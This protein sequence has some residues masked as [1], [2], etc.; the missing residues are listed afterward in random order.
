[1]MKNTTHPL[2][3]AALLCLAG[4]PSDDTSGDTATSSTGSTGG[5]TTQTPTTDPGS[6]STSVGSTSSASTTEDGTTSTGTVDTGSSSSEGSSSSSGGETLSAIVSAYHGLDVLPAGGAVVLCGPPGVGQDGM[7]VAFAFQLNGDTVVP[8]NFSVRDPDGNDVTPTCATLAPADEPLELHTV[9]LAGP[10][11][12]DGEIPL[13]VEVTGPVETLDG[14]SLEGE[15]TEDV[16]PLADGPALFLAERYPPDQPG[17]A[18]E[19]PKGTLQVVQMAWQGGVTGPAGA[20]LDE[21]QRLAVHVTLENDEVV[22]PI[23]LADDDPDN[24]VHACLDRDSPA[25]SIAVDRGFFHDPGD[26]PNPATEIDVVEGSLTGV[27]NGLS[28]HDRE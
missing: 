12:M 6:S 24:Y 16:T 4:C 28:A 26:D 8:E 10:F 19:C 1:M 18:G 7:P 5:E 17:L 14:Q 13:S 23:A 15:F 11:S 3:V 21:P 27:Q 9:L 2:C 20:A 22:E 25:V